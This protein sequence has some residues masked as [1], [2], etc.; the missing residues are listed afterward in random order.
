MS[1]ERLNLGCGTDIRPGWVNLD[2]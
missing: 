1:N 2:V